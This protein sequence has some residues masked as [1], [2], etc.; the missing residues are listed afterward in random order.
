M[1]PNLPTEAL[2]CRG[3][4]VA[5]AGGWTETSLP[6]FVYTYTCMYAH[7]HVNTHLYLCV[8]MLIL[9][10]NICACIYTHTH[11]RLCVAG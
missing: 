2:R 6:Q 11:V 3:T 7:T 10:Y 5:P 8:H 4:E 1:F 9:Y